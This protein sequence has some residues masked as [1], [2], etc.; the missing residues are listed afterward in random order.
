MIHEMGLDR[1]LQECLQRFLWKGDIQ[2][3]EDGQELSKR[4]VKSGMERVKLRTLSLDSD[5]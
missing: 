3:G 1:V 5:Y 2:S 4:K